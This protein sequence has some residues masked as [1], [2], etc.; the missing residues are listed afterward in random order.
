MNLSDVKRREYSQAKSL[1]FISAVIQWALFI[2]S[3]YAIFKATGDLATV[4]G[5]LAFVAP[6]VGFVLKQA[7]GRYYSSGERVRRLLYLQDGLGRQSS[8]ADLLD[9]A[10]SATSVPSLDPEPLDSEFTS[11]LPSGPQRLA[12]I[13]QEAAFYTRS[14]ARSTSRFYS[15]LAVGGLAVTIV[16]LLLLVQHPTPALGRVADPTK[17]WVKAASMLLVFFATGTFAERAA[18][19]LSLSSSA[20]SVFDRCELLRKQ[21]DVQESGVLLAMG[22]YDAALAKAQPLPGWV[23]RLRR[24]RLHEAWKKFMAAGT[25]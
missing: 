3:L 6:I 19:F 8:S 20:K 5:I 23:Y 24:E 15:A 12:H 16:G 2:G 14:L 13:I 1:G 22:T 25:M 9:V 10:E 18:S 7:A 4:L 17:T 11:E 21:P